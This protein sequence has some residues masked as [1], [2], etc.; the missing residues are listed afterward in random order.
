MLRASFSPAIANNR[1]LISYQTTPAYCHKFTSLVCQVCDLH[2]LYIYVSGCEREHAKMLFIRKWSLPESCSLIF[3]LSYC[4]C[5]WHVLLLSVMY[6]YNIANVL[7]LAAFCFLCIV[8][9]AIIGV[10]VAKC[11]YCWFMKT[12]FDSGGNHC[13][14]YCQLITI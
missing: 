1:L 8:T 13:T 10:F 7:G 2:Q 4:L 3:L 14:N 6:F 12:D 9:P 5:Y 11:S